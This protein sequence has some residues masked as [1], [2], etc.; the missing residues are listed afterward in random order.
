VHLERPLA[1]R[2]PPDVLGAGQK[3]GSLP[4][5]LTNAVTLRRADGGIGLAVLTLSGLPMSTYQEALASAAPLLL[6]QQ[7]LLDDALLARLRRAVG[8]G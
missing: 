3:G 6:T 7:V 5:V 8:S 1:G 4:G 2:L